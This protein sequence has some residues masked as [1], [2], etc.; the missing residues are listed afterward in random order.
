M[1]DRLPTV[2]SPIPR[3]LRV[4]LDRLRDILAAKGTSK[5]LTVADLVAAGVL[6]T[7]ATGVISPAGSPAGTPP[8]PLGVTATPAV[9]TILVEWT[10]PAYPGHAFA[11]VWSGGVDSLGTAVLL[12]MAPGAVYV[13]AVGPGVARYYWVRFVNEA[14]V[15]GPFNA[16]GGTMATTTP[17]LT[18]LMDT[19]AEEY[20]TGSAAPFFQVD[21]PT[22][23]GGVTIPAGTYMKAAFIHDATIDNAKIADLA[24]DNAKIAAVSAGKITT[25]V[26]GV[27]V[28]IESQ[29]YS[30]GTAGWRVD[31]SGAA[32]FANVAIRGTVYAT[33]G[34]FNGEVI[35]VSP[36]GEMARMFSGNFELY[37]NVPGAG[38]V[39]YNTLSRIETGVGLSGSVVTIPGYFS[40]PPTVIVSPQSLN[41]YDPGYPAQAQALR[42]EV[43]GL[44]ENPAASQIWQF[45]PT[46]TLNIAGNDGYVA[47]GTS[48]GDVTVPWT[49]PTAPTT[50]INTTSI[51]GAV[52]AASR[53]DVTATLGVNLPYSLSPYGNVCAVRAVRARVEYYSGGAWLSGPWTS[54]VLAKSESA[55]TPLAP[56]VLPSA[57]AYPVRMRCEA[58]D[59]MTVGGTSG[60][61]ALPQDGTILAAA[62]PTGAYTSSS[63]GGMEVMHSAVHNGTIWVCVGDNGCIRTSTDGITWTTVSSVIAGRTY[64]RVVWDGAQF[65]VVGATLSNGYILTSPD[66]YTWT[67]RYSGSALLYDISCTATGNNIA[68]GKIWVGP[69][70]YNGVILHSPTGVTWTSV[71]TTSAVSVFNG[72][73][74]GV[75]AGAA[76]F[77][78]VGDN[79]KIFVSNSTGLSWAVTYAGPATG[80]EFTA[81]AWS[82]TKFV[83]VARIMHS[84]TPDAGATS[85]DGITWTRIPDMPGAL[86]VIWTGSEFVAV[87]TSAH[88]GPDTWWVATS[89]TGATWTTTTY[90]GAVPRGVASAGSQYLV[91]TA[92]NNWW[93]W[94][95]GAYPPP[96]PASRDSY[97]YAGHTWHLGS[98]AVL[99]TGTVSWVAVGD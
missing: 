88:W 42:C 94:F 84:L 28:Y 67:P 21:T 74:Y 34:Q 85:S 86:D 9:R 61:P 70:A 50:P 44:V 96:S 89:T 54:A 43:T 51:D 39:K 98:A 15:A 56:N 76:K 55:S 1:S 80:S 20:G 46:A 83:A 82:G 5:L 36:S 53:H 65:M 12:G 14:G 33:D 38:L 6:V 72:V 59:F 99:A 77:V 37:K 25:D 16:V 75:A 97:V 26:L 23:I 29:G 10:P 64:R 93:H 47:D 13:D 49:S 45:T 32:E 41:T 95:V 19:L 17:E 63:T 87:G 35:A 58:A 79:Y 71:L 27:G 62:T 69:G 66:G 11:E 73:T 40:S 7:D 57:G 68:V 18:Y 92:Q 4:Y 24:V 48:S 60:W 3:D 78:A 8:S 30:P 52:T 90:T 22:V 91:L 81:V 31:A 2:T